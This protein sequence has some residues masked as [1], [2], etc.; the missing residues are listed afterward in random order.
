MFKKITVLLLFFAVFQGNAQNVLDELKSILLQNN[1]FLFEKYCYDLKHNFSDDYSVI[2]NELVSREILE[3]YHESYFEIDET[4][5]KDGER[6]DHKTFNIRII[7][8][9]DTIL[10][11]E[12]AEEKSHKNSDGKWS[13]EETVQI[14]RSN[15]ASL[16]TFKQE[17]L[18]AYH[19]QF[20]KDH[21]FV[22]NITFGYSCG[23]GGGPLKLR[24]QLREFVEMR[25]TVAILDWLSC[26]TAEL[27]LYAID[28]V[29][30]LKHYGFHFEAYIYDIMKLISI[31]EGSVNSCF[32]CE[33]GPSSISHLAAEIFKRHDFTF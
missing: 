2:I 20:D 26:G 12:V 24:K 9:C 15:A 8:N 28:G 7:S 33:F 10:F 22:K 31:K 32:G 6:V 18:D 23:L 3:Q 14:T 11:Y 30:A 21:L 1:Y 25:D 29:L 13:T 19:A 17:Y 4:H 27:Q 16:R 5:W